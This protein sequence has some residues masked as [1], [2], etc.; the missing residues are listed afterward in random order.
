[1]KR[2]LRLRAVC[3]LALA[4]IVVSCATPTP[5]LVEKVVTQTVRETVI[6]EGTPR[7]VEKEVTRVVEVEVTKVVQVEQVPEEQMVVVALSDDP[8]SL[9]RR[10]ASPSMATV[11]LSEQI[12][13]FLVR[14]DTRSMTFVPELAASWSMSD[15]GLVWTIYLRRGL[16]F[17]DGSDLTA[18]D[19]QWTM[20]TFRLEEYGGNYVTDYATIEETRIIDDYTWQVS[21]G[22]PMAPFKF[23]NMMA[24]PIYR[25]ASGTDLE[26]EF[27]PVGLGPFKLVSWKKDVEVVLEAFDG[28]VG[29]RPFLDRVVWRIIP[30]ATVQLA[31]LEAGT[32][33]I[34]L[35][36]TQDDA[37][38]L[39][40]LEQIEIF[41][42]P[43]LN[44]F[45]LGLNNGTS[46]PLGNALVRQAIAHAIDREDI[47]A[48]FPLGATPTNNPLPPTNWA[49]NPDVSVYEYEPEEARALLAAAGYAD[50][51]KTTIKLPAGSAELIP[52]GEIIK[53]HLSEIGIEAELVT[54]E[55]ATFF[56][57]IVARDS[58]MYV[59]RW[60]NVTDPDFLRLICHSE[61]YLN[62]VSYANAEVDRLLEKGRITLNR[63]QRRQVYHEALA[64]IAEEVPYVPLVSTD[65]YHAYNANLVGFGPVVLAYQ[66][67][68][69]L[70]TVRWAR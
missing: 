39:Q 23:W 22:E 12:D 57:D 17:H 68:W 30:D 36:L 60:S 19:V 33:D 32:V 62:R 63:E 3:V 40:A 50:G 41:E 54:L 5:E 56:A 64:I 45:Y 44:F 26:G 13:G 31:E 46:E 21:L 70:A 6:V 9:D 1:M 7:T 24:F 48:I 11:V 58:E 69:Y 52:I 42:G 2:V 25:E 66:F 43:G 61:S 18:A 51:F 10:Y 37:S 53:A 8:Q 28:Y 29:G 67:P 15:D 65:I 14:L 47:A 38:R 16:T 34:V 59:L 4:T 20:N 49:Y 35:D 55:G 27:E